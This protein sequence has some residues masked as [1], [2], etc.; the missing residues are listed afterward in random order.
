MRHG[1]LPL[2]L[3]AAFATALAAGSAQAQQRGAPGASPGPGRAGPAVSAPAAVGRAAGPAYSAPATVGRAAGPAVSA[4]GPRMSAPGPDMRGA[5]NLAPGGNSGAQFAGK[6]W[7][8]KHWHGGHHRRHG[9]VAFGFGAYPYWDPYYD[10]Y[11]YDP[12]YYDAEPVYEVAPDATDSD[13][14]YC[15]RTFRSYDVRSGTY[16]GTDGRRHPCP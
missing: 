12:Y 5:P 3:L 9:G 2:I 7:S 6:N 1:K 8:G 11:A 10:S 16:R 14:E 15:R 13:V 4:P